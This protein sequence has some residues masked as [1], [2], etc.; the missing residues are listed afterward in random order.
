[1]KICRVLVHVTFHSILKIK[2]QPLCLLSKIGFGSSGSTPDWACG[3]SCWAQ[4]P[5]QLLSKDKPHASPYIKLS[6]ERKRVVSTPQLNPIS[7]LNVSYSSFLL[8][9]HLVFLSSGVDLLCGWNVCSPGIKGSWTH[10]HPSAVPTKSATNKA[11]SHSA[12]STFFLLMNVQICKWS[13]A[14]KT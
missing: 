2:G 3:S 6:M 9:E 8:A 4:A 13:T 1:M 11:S 5:G 7:T 10:S 14:L 12:W